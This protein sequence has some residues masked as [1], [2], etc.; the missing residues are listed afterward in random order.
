MTDCKHNFQMTPQTGDYMSVAKCTL[1]PA[2]MGASLAEKILND[3]QNW[4]EVKAE[5]ARQDI[6]WGDKRTHPDE[7]WYLILSEEFGELGKAVLENHFGYPGVNLEQIRNE[8]VHTIAV[9]V[10]WLRSIR[11]DNNKAT[12]IGGLVYK[13]TPLTPLE[14]LE[15]IGKLPGI[16]EAFADCVH[17][18]GTG[19]RKPEI[20]ELSNVGI[21]TICSQCTEIFKINEPLKFSYECPECGFDNYMGEKKVDDG[22]DTK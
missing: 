16:Q 2:V 3:T 20:G 22:H 6:K 15:A 8:L 9:G 11:N 10:Q 5:M 1:C 4:E 17:C 19:F 13:P 14:A 21:L 18:E 7:T 12:V